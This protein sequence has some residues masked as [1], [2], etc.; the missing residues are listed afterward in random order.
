[1]WGMYLAVPVLA[2]T[3]ILYLLY[4]APNV[5]ERLFSNIIMWAIITAMA[6]CIGFLQTLA[7]NYRF[8]DRYFVDL[9]TIGHTCL[10]LLL[11]LVFHAILNN[12]WASYAIAQAI[13]IGWEILEIILKPIWYKAYAES[14]LNSTGDLIFGAIGSLFAIYFI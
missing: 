9:Y 2:I 1:M 14:V 13:H 5:P 8:K 7:K 3:L 10:P 12:F 11:T 6:G 4:F